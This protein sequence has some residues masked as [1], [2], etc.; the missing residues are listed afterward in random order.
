M[1][2]LLEHLA[3]F[4]ISALDEN[5]LEPG[6]VD[7][8]RGATFAGGFAGTERANIGGR[9]LHPIR[10]RLALG[11]PDTLPESVEL[12]FG[13][14]TAH[15][16]Q[17]RLLNTG[18]GLGELVG[19]FAVVGDQQK[20]LAQ[21]VEATD[22]VEALAGLGEKLHDG[23]AALG[24]ADGGHISLRLVKHEVTMTLRPLQ[25]LAIDPDVIAAC[26]GFAAKFCD[27][28][29][30]HLDTAGGD[31]LFSVAPARDSRFGE[32]LLQ[33]LQVDGTLGCMHLPILVDFGN[34]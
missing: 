7:W 31:Q 8:A 5:D 12:F 32:D 2:D 34:L 11:N 25:K 3:E 29:A 18:C 24:I 26:V 14:L 27:H 6:I 28:G 19:Q 20:T 21:V 10:T 16:D 17:I 1:T 30:V 4:A 23:R 15:F 13:R 9:G 22:R 33:A